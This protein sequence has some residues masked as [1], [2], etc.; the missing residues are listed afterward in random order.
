M[1]TTKIKSKSEDGD[2]DINADPKRKNY[3]KIRM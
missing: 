2:Y 1:K 3:K